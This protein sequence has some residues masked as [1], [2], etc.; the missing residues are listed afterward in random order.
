MEVLVITLVTIMNLQDLEH[1]A[2]EENLSAK[3]DEERY[4]ISYADTH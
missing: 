1:E 4:K 2:K 3:E